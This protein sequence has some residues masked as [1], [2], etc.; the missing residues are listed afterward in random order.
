MKMWVPPFVQPEILD[1]LSGALD[2]IAEA[3]S[4]E[5]RPDFR[6]Q[7][8]DTLLS[9]TRELIDRLATAVLR[10]ANSQRGVDQAKWEHVRQ[11]FDHLQRRMDLLHPKSSAHFA[12]TL[13]WM[14]QC[15]DQDDLRRLTRMKQDP[16]FE[17]P[18]VEK[19]FELAIAGIN[20]RSGRAAHLDDVH[21]QLHAAAEAAQ[22]Q[23]TEWERDYQ[24][25][26]LALHAG[27]V[28]AHDAAKPALLS[29]LARMQRAN[30]PFRACIVRVGAPVLTARGPRV[31]RRPS[32]ALS[33][34][35]E[36]D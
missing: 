2:A 36:I 24:G 23:K 21:S 10:V 7:L 19:L 32:S 8:A 26:Y 34:S 13:R 15:G 27:A 20:G 14:A 4:V 25:L 12:T 17:T 11:R 33:R 3:I 35:P 22:T 30:G 9:T 28:V 29:Q 6:R 5:P 1:D 31:R 18:A 16:P